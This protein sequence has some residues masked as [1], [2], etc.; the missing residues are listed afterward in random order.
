MRL[1][2]KSSLVLAF[3][4]IGLFF[5]VAHL[6]APGGS[7]VTP[8]SSRRPTQNQN[9][10]G[11]SDGDEASQF[12]LTHFQRS[13]TRNGR[14]VWEV[15]ADNGKYF[16]NLEITRLKNV[17]V[18]STR[19]EDSKLTVAADSADVRLKGT[20]LSF[21]TLTSKV[22]ATINDEV[23]VTT[24]KATYDYEGSI[25]TAPEFVTI[26]GPFYTS[27]GDSMVV[28]TEEEIITLEGNVR[29]QIE[30]VP[31]KKGTEE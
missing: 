22:I 11:Q 16:P 17:Q 18:I 19:S 2:R 4:T 23:T 9:T 7:S 8:T 14:K 6:T 12:E 28:D 5:T 24:E 20:S 10:S 31:K 30:P 29:T 26:T 1:N 13:E 21:A 15:T 27:E 25:I 3:A